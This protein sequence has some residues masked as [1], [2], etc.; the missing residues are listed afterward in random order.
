MYFLISLK[1]WKKIQDLVLVKVMWKSWIKQSGM[2]KYNRQGH[3]LVLYL[4][5]LR[6]SCLASYS[7]VRKVS[8]CCMYEIECVNPV[9]FSSFSNA[10]FSYTYS[11]YG[12][13]LL[14]GL[15]KWCRDASCHNFRSY[16]EPSS[17]CELI[18]LPGTF[19]IICPWQVQLKL[20]TYWPLQ[21]TIL[22]PWKF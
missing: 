4:Y 16:F 20:G 14:W 15:W 11:G 19:Y 22:L 1:F 2:Q 21:M 9:F 18:S 12:I 17:L 13:S 8:S 10:S 7:F 5:F 3:N 6:L